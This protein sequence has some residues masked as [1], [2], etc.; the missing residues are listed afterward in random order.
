M[1]LQTLSGKGVQ[2]VIFHEF[3]DEPAFPAYTS[4][5]IP[6]FTR[7]VSKG[8]LLRVPSPEARKPRYTDALPLEK[9]RVGS[10]PN[11]A[12]TVALFI[13]VSTQLSSS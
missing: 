13:K 5:R 10:T 11:C 6:L 8:A 12:L 7:L 3:L 1:K 2:V 4:N 9:F